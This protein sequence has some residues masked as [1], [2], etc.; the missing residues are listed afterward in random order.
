MPHK[1]QL[2]PGQ[3]QRGGPAGGIGLLTA[4]REAGVGLGFGL[5]RRLGAGNMLLEEGLEESWNVPR[6]CRKS[7]TLSS[8]LRVGAA[9]GGCGG[10]GGG[11]V[12]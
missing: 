3:P 8:P 1:A 2:A 5:G 12:Q 11:R 6:G 9:G 7:G 4:K 10:A